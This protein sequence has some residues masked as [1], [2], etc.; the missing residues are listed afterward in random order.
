MR[1]DCQVELALTRPCPS[2]RPPHAPFITAPPST[3]NTLSSQIR[4]EMSFGP[5]NAGK[6]GN[7][8]HSI[9][10]NWGPYST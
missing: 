5:S 9:K 6:P 3:G 1:G 7:D 10:E 8:T 4:G 2:D